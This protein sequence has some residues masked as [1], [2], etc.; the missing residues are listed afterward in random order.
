MLVAG[1][2]LA[3]PPGT[4][5]VPR[6]GPVPPTVRSVIPRGEAAVRALPERHSPQVGVV[7]AVA[8]PFLAVSPAG[9]GCSRW[10][11]QLGEG[12]WLCGSE[13]LLSTDPAPTPPSLVAHPL[14]WRYGVTLRPAQVFASAADARAGRALETWAPWQGFVVRSV[15][16]DGGVAVT[17]TAAGQFLLRRDVQGVH[18]SGFHGRTGEDLH[19]DAPEALA[20]WVLVG[21]ATSYGTPEEAALGR[22]EGPRL[23]HLEA[24]R[25]LERRTVARRDV[26]R[27]DGGRWVRAAALRVFTP[28]PAPP[29]VD[30]AARQRW[31]DVDLDQQVIAAFEGERL[32]Y[33]TLT[34]TGSPEAETP[35]GV[36]NIRSR[37]LARDMGFRAGHGHLL[38]RVPYTQFFDDDGRALHGVYW[39]DGFGQPR[40]HGC[41]NLSFTDAAWFFAFTG[42]LPD[43]WRAVLLA[44]GE[45]TVLR[46]RGRT[47]LGSSSHQRRVEAPTAEAPSPVPRHRHHR[48]HGRHGRHHHRH[49][50]RHHPRHHRH[51]GGQP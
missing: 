42:S 27:I 11:F 16:R 41:I 49:H 51:H 10:W 38:A 22:G 37:H 13:V 9:S 32:V 28:S 29:G 15:H 18:P 3:D 45:G 50:H 30:L 47:P 36:Y 40:S 17:E 25:V 19:R 39:H 26:V 7:G 23:A 21:R 1:A 2:A 8:F 6:D 44:P 31:I 34:S 33:V 43:G 5:P 35:P 12:R 48:H 14:R 20:A 46:V 24:L 4:L